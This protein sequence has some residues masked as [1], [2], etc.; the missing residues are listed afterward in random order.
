MSNTTISGN[1]LSGSGSIEGG[2]LC[3]LYNAKATIRDSFIR[4]NMAIG[5]GWVSGAG[6]NMRSAKCEWS[7]V[8]LS[9]NTIVV[10]NTRSATGRGYGAGA[11]ADG[12]LAFVLTGCTFQG[13]L[14]TLSPIHATK[15]VTVMGAGIYTETNMTMTACALVSNVISVTPTNALI[16]TARGAGVYQK[17]GAALMRRVTLRGNRMALD[18]NCAQ[19]SVAEGGGT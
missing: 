7:N 3:C 4:G 6:I 14:I 9:N 19:T 13:N 17:T 11:Y 10:N 5:D 16:V 18:G 2:A 8:D 12:G 1:V 15:S